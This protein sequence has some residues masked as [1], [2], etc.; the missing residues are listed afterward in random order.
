MGT[1]TMHGLLRQRESKWHSIRWRSGS[2]QPLHIR[3]LRW[4]SFEK[5]SLLSGIKFKVLEHVVQSACLGDSSRLHW[6]NMCRVHAEDRRKAFLFN[7]LGLENT[8]ILM[9]ACR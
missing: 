2:K 4:P 1:K 5:H 6:T 7:Y 8:F 9:N 3:L